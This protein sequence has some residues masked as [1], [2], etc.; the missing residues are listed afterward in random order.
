MSGAGFIVYY[1]N[2]IT[3]LEIQIERDKDLHKEI[4]TLMEFQKSIL[5][6]TSEKFQKVD[7]AA[8]NIP[9]K[10]VSGDFFDIIKIPDGFVAMIGD[11]SGKSLPAAFFMVMT[12]SVIRSIIENTT[13]TSTSKLMTDI[14][15]IIYPN[16][17][18]GMFLTLGIV[19]YSE[20]NRMVN[21]YSAGHNPFIFYQA[22]T[23]KSELI[24]PK[25]L[26][27][28]V[29]ENN[30]FKAQTIH[31]SK[32]DV[33]II[34]SDGISEAYAPNTEEFGERRIVK[35]MESNL[36]LSAKNL[37]RKITDETAIFSKSRE[38]FDDQTIV[39]LRWKE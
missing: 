12:F 23:K 16:S 15:R 10:E 7:F 38:P 18:K 32:G 20:K 29:L 8:I 27:I 1:Q 4:L 9:A 30:R 24:K 22:K 14:N 35:I 33:L 17:Q 19:F 26:P 11:V 37:A 13:E 3:G 25:G 21:L 28:G 39:V 2:M 34:Y 6:V 31:P 36:D 5:K